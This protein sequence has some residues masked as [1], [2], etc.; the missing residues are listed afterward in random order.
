M[1][2]YE[3]MISMDVKV[4]S[5]TSSDASTTSLTLRVC[6]GLDAHV[7]SWLVGNNQPEVFD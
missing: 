1:F 6:Y 5:S 2:V 4:F 3:S 7:C